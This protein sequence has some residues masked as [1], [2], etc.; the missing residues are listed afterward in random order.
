LTATCT[1]SAQTPLVAGS[2]VLGLWLGP[3][4]A[5]F[6]NYNL[7]KAP[8][9]RAELRLSP[10]APSRATVIIGTNASWLAHASTTTHLGGWNSGDYGGDALDWSKD[11]PGWSTP[12]ANVSD[13]E[14]ATVFQLAREI[15]PQV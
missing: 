3:G 8:L 4:W 2:N 11:V 1:G 14:A 5:A 10:P 13:W 12:A 6:P 9:V 15:L 7:S